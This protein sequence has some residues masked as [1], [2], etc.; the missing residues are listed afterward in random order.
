[1]QEM[2]ISATDSPASWVTPV[3]IRR[4]FTDPEL[5]YHLIDD[6]FLHP[7]IGPFLRRYL[8]S[9]EDMDDDDDEMG[10]LSTGLCDTRGLACTMLE[11]WEIEYAVEDNDIGKAIT[12]QHLRRNRERFSTPHTARDPNKIEEVEIKSDDLK[13]MICHLPKVGRK[14]AIARRVLPTLPSSPMHVEEQSP[15]G[16]YSM[17]VQ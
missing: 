13:G 3:S 6:R 2:G 5:G 1:M 16:A 12:N 10:H 11:D 17:E 4:W 14:H 8:S 15:R 7:L 9:F